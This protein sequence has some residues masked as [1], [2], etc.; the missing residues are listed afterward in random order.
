MPTIRWKR[1]GVDIIPDSNTSISADGLTLKNVRVESEGLYVCIARN[2]AGEERASAVLTVVGM[3]FR[4]IS[5][6]FGCIL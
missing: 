3:A 5:A 1:N 2:I 6:L 4:S